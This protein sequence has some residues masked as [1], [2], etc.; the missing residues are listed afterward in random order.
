MPPRV[1]EFRTVLE[2]NGFRLARSRDHE[3]WVQDDDAGRV[4]RRVPVSHGNAEI[5]T[6]GLFNRMLRQAGKTEE[7]FYEVLK[8]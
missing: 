4:A 3:I 2:R 6:R 1:S 5:R 7:R 8:G